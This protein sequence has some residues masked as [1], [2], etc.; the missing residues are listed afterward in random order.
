[1]LISN[2]LATFIL[3][4][5]KPTT[6][7]YLT[8]LTSLVMELRRKLAD[9]EVGMNLLIKDELFE[10]VERTPSFHVL[11]SL[12]SDYHLFIQKHAQITL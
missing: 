4:G 6:L 9:F 10:Y 8:T 11:R 12:K 3:L 7:I 1:M 2:K 5:P